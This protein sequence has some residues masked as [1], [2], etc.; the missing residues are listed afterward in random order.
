M[1]LTTPRLSFL[2]QS[3]PSIHPSIHPLINHI[4][5]LNLSIY[6][7]Y[8]YHYSQSVFVHAL[9]GRLKD[10][11]KLSLAGQRF[12]NGAPV[13]G[14][15]LLPAAFVEQDVNFFPH[16][17]VRETLDFRVS[18]KLGSLVTKHE[19]DAMVKNLMGQLGLTKS[20]DTIVGNTKVRG[21][22]GGTYVVIYYMCM[23]A[24]H[25]FVACCWKVETHSVRLDAR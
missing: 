10:N 4:H 11:R 15:S 1:E 16:M 21:L 12:I 3:H 23:G 20:A 7:H 18:L 14:D 17:T 2:N 24:L 9:A 19:R 22:S 6:T 8:Y 5:T 13:Q 25:Y